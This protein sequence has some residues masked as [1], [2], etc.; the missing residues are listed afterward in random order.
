MKRKYRVVTKNFGGSVSVMTDW[1]TRGE[2][3]KFIIGRWGHV[4]P[5]AFISRAQN[6]NLKRIYGE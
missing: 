6:Q 4:P 1:Q 2:C 5:F 3:R